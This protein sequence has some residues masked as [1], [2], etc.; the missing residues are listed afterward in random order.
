VFGILDVLSYL[1]PKSAIRF[2]G[3]K[4][5][6]FNYHQSNVAAHATLSLA[7]STFVCGQF[8]DRGT[9]SNAG[10][11][12]NSVIT[13]A[14]PKFI[15]IGKLPQRFFVSGWFK[16]WKKKL[17]YRVRDY[18]RMFDVEIDWSQEMP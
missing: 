6:C 13:N 12:K 3:L 16:Q 7:G 9:T 5:K 11:L 2:R 15:V 14:V 8:L 17:Q 4:D 1:T 18:R 10:A